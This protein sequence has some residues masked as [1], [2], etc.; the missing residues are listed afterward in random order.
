MFGVSRVNAYLIVLAL[1]GVSFWGWGEWQYRAGWVEGRA[2]ME[3][4]QRR[5][6]ERIR[7]GL[8]NVETGTGDIDVDVCAI[9]RRLRMVP[10][11]PGCE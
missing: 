7:E 10:A 1:A 3:L 8:R 11:P 2:A 6:A 4:E 9:A 5:A